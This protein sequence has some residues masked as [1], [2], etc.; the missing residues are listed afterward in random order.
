MKEI[1]A[2]IQPFML[3][4]VIEALKAMEDLPGVTVSEV[5][6]FGK[7]RALA[8]SQPVTLDL[9]DYAKKVK[10]EIVIPDRLVRQVVEKIVLTARTG[11]AGD[12]KIF[13]LSVDEVIKI[14][15]GETGDLAI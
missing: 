4:R 3:S 5:I 8:T 6:G 12:G 13:V 2:I 7:A 14:R 15:T 11:G 1:K 9:I 10:L